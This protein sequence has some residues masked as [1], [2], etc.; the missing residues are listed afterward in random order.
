MSAT[1]IVRKQNL[2][3]T[4]P[5]RHVVPFRDASEAWREIGHLMGPDTVYIEL[6]DSATGEVFSWVGGKRK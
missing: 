6:S 5:T 4:L 2:P 3:G 1:I